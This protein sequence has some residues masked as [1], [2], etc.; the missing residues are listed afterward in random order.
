[1]LRV[2]CIAFDRRATQTLC[3]YCFAVNFVE[4]WNTFTISQIGGVLILT[5]RQG[6][7]MY[8][9]LC[10]C[11]LSRQQNLD[12]EGSMNKKHSGLN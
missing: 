4:L 2:Y 7:M 6:W 12:N 8:H 10:V 11:A 5:G 3:M 9:V 1:M